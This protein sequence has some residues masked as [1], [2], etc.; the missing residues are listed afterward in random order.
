MPGT[1]TLLVALTV[2]ALA[3]AG[4]VAFWL[5]RRRWQRGGTAVAYHHFRCPNCHRRLR[6]Q[7]HQVGRKGECSH[8]GQAVTFPPVSQ[9]VD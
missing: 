1:T 5:A 8:C 4:G 3:L 2:A 7:S 9:S 6:F